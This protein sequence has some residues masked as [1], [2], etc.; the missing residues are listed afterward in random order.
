MLTLCLVVSSADKLCKQFGL[1]S[2]FKL[3]DTLVVFLNIYFFEKKVDFER[4]RLK[5]LQTTKRHDKLPSRQ[6]VKHTGKMQLRLLDLLIGV[7]PIT[8]LRTCLM[9]IVPHSREIT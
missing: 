3:F 4:K 6:R 7:A 5:N 2:S 1:R 9:K 8:Q